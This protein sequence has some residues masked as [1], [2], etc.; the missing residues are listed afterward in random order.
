MAVLDAS[1]LAA[2]SSTVA[3]DAV[4]A[5]TASAGFVGGASFAG[6]GAAIRLSSASFLGTSL[7]AWDY[8][9][10][11]AGEVEG[12]SSATASAHRARTTGA[13]FLGRSSFVYGT[14]LPIHGSSFFSVAIVVDQHLPPLSAAAG[15][16]KT[17]RW[18]QQLQRGDLAVF[19][20]GPAIPVRISY[21]LAQVRPDGSRKHVGP[22]ARS[23]SRGAVG[24]FYATGRAGEAGQPGDWVIEWTYQ[25]TAQSH[26]ERSE[27][28]FRVLD[29]VQVGEQRELLD[30]KPKTGW[31]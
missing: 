29:A 21:R 31:I 13:G 26:P 4:V 5:L 7:A 2:G 22:K 15:A 23:P 14:L 30:R 25:R 20:C 17:F 18:L 1:G 10:E 9:L 27:M 11:A 28:A 24:E 3:A 12:V 6:Q 8:Q 16:T 19:L